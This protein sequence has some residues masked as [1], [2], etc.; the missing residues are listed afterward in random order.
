MVNQQTLDATFAALSDPIRRGVLQR[1]AI[2]PASVSSLAE[3]YDI[4]LPGML[5][6]V[7]VLERAH[8]VETRKQGRTRNC[9]IKTEPF[10]E[11]SRWLEQTRRTWESRFDS[12]AAYLKTIQEEPRP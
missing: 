12:L 7:R 11:A 9:L 1:L 2:Q 10:S 8:L 3:D 5:K 6:H 4:S